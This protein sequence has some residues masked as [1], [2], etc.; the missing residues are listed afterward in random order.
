MPTSHVPKA[1]PKAPQN[2]PWNRLILTPAIAKGTAISFLVF[3]SV[4]GLRSLLAQWTPSSTPKASPLT[5]NA[6]LPS[7]GS[8]DA[9]EPLPAGFPPVTAEQLIQMVPEA[10]PQRLQQLVPHLNQAMAKFGINTR[11]RQAHLLAQIA[12]ESDRFMALEAARSGADYE[13][14]KDLGNTQRGDGVKFKPRGLIQLVGRTNYAAASQALGVDLIHQPQRL[15]D[16]ELAALSAGWF[17]STNQLNSDADKDDVKTVTKIVNGGYN[18][19]DD[20]KQL[21]QA[22]KKALGMQPKKKR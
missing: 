9:P 18:G 8:M 19:L 1:P 14:R 6:L 20:R 2:R 13:G 5:S 4:C 7:F 21:L 12:H 3:M 22:A 17:W 16:P 15:A 11:L 10:N